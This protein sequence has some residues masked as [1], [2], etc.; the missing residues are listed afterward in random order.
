MRNLCGQGTTDVADVELIGSV[1]DGHL[2]PLAHIVVV[3]N[4]LVSNLGYRE[5]TPQEAS[6]FSVLRID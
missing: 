2:A 6:D 3:A 1:V 4:H 5:A